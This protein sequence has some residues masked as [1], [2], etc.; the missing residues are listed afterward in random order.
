MEEYVTSQTYFVFV[1]RF[2]DN[3]FALAILYD[4]YEDL[5]K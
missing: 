3:I 2:E 5:A 4:Y 1:R